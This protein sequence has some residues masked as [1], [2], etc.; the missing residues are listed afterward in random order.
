VFQVHIPTDI[1]QHLSSFQVHQHHA[2]IFL[3]YL[4]ISQTTKNIIVLLDCSQNGTVEFDK[5]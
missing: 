2:A 4:L 3:K 5:A 1:Q